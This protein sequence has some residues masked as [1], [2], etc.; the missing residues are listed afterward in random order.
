ML[1]AQSFVGP[2]IDWYRLSNILVILGGALVLLLVGSLTPKWPR[3]MY[4]LGA[5]VTTGASAVLTVLLWRDL[6]DRQSIS[7]VEI[8]RA[9]V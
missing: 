5:A 7:L 8:G 4:A 2:A 9:H 3:G 6:G 1:A